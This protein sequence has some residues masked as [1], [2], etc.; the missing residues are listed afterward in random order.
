VVEL[1][2]LGERRTS[3]H[4]RIPDLLIPPAIV[5]TIIAAIVPN[6]LLI[7]AT[8]IISA[9]TSTHLRF[10]FLILPAMF[11]IAS[12]R[13]LIPANVLIESTLRLNLSAIVDPAIELG[14][15]LAIVLSLMLAPM[16]KKLK[17]NGME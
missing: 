15:T 14:H 7:I 5:L 4:L 17:T 11:L 3:T 10:A 8:L 16:I 12:T 2:E 1:T 13:S 6:L 9:I